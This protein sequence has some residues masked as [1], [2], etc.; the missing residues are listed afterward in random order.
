MGGAPASRSPPSAARGLVNRSHLGSGGALPLTEPRSVRVAWFR[1]AAREVLFRGILTPAL[2]R[3]T[4]EGVRLRPG[5]KH[6]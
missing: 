4:G 3:P 1:G 6:R 5:K 2:S